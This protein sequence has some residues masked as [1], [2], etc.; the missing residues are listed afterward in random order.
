MRLRW[1][2]LITLILVIG[3]MIFIFHF[4]GENAEASSETSGHLTG[5]LVETVS[6]ILPEA[7]QNGDVQSEVDYW[8]G[9]I[10][11]CAHFL[12]Y[13]VLSIL[14]NFHI[15]AVELMLSGDS[16]TVKGSGCS[17]LCCG[18]YAGTDELHQLF[19]PGRACRIFDIGIDT[20]G[21]FFGTLLFLTLMKQKVTMCLT[22]HVEHDRK[23]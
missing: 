12:E 9:F 22:M 4:S 14:V 3:M 23:E 17:I 11:K 20:V 7:F 10:R 1:F 19:V 6:K 2:W 8:E 18:L 15:L 13:A 5:Y 16:R 21:A